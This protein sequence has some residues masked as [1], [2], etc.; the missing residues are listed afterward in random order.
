MEIQCHKD[1]NTTHQETKLEDSLGEVYGKE[2]ELEEST[3]RLRQETDSVGV[4]FKKG[5]M[6]VAIDSLA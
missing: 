3:K 4:D 5:F 1:T 6:N 2:G